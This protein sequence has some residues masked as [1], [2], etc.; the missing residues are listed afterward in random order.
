MEKHS[1]SIKSSLPEINKVND[2]FDVLLSEKL[3]DILVNE[4]KIK[5][6]EEFKVISYELFSNCIIHNE[7]PTICY[8]VIF[9]SGKVELT[10]YSE[11]KGFSLK[12]IY[13]YG[14]DLV[15]HAP[16]PDSILNEIFTVYEGID[17]KVDCIILGNN[18]IRFQV[19]KLENPSFETDTLPEHFGLYLIASLT[20]NFE[21]SRSEKG[22]DIY[23][24]SK[25]IH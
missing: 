23:K 10:I 16:F 15:Y 11:G 1:F 13:N 6:L 18:K 22:V 9:N 24:I 14:N 19:N 25:L 3:G 17:S 20:D 12:P 21:Y 5:F 7:S 2:A 4:R 8:E